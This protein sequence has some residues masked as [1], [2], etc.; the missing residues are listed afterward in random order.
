MTV[1]VVLAGCTGGLTG[2]EAGTGT[3]SLYLSDQPNAIDDFDRLDVTVTR[4]GFHYAANDSWVNR[5]LDEKTV[6]LTR[7]RGENATLLGNLSIPA[8]EYRKVFIHVETVDGTLTGGDAA[9][10]QLPSSRLQLTL[11]FTVEPD[12]T[13]AFVY[14]VTVQQTGQGKYVLKPQ[15]A[16]SGPDRPFTTVDAQVRHADGNRTTT[17]ST[18]A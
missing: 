4:V 3:V 16:E 18:A 12:E 7:L 6:D 15:V 9:E 1:V 13:L 5:S 17:T 14:D 8:V 11:G 10:V 2:G